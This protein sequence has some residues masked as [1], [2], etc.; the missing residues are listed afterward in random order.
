MNNRPVDYLFMDA[1]PW[2]VI[3]A[4]LFWSLISLIPFYIAK[5]KGH[6]PYISFFSSLVSGPLRQL[7]HLFTLPN[8]DPQDMANKNPQLS[9]QPYTYTSQ[10]HAEKLDWAYNSLVN[11]NN[12]KVKSAFPNGKSQMSEI[13]IEILRFCGHDPDKC[14]WQL[15]MRAASVY[16]ELLEP[17]DNPDIEMITTA[18]KDVLINQSNTLA[19]IQH[20]TRLK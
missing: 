19:L 15:Y 16:L 5:R 7:L 4:L 14:T 3:A 9:S 6:N 12:D 8:D 1:S 11:T 17:F 18:H 20:F 2:E 13:I 10:T